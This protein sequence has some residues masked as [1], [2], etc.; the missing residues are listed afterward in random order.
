MEC[1]KDDA[2]NIIHFNGRWKR[3][4]QQVLADAAFHFESHREVPT[5]GEARCRPW[6][7]CRQEEEERPLYLASRVHHQQTYWAESAKQLSQLI[8]EDS[9]ASHA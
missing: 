7:C 8:L 5:Y 3:A 1:T 6:I 2:V 4:E 9:T